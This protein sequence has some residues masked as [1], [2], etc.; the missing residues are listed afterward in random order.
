MA[1]HRRGMMAA[2][3]RRVSSARRDTA[4]GE[5]SS[6]NDMKSVQTDTNI[7][8]WCGVHKRSVYTQIYNTS[9]GYSAVQF[10]LTAVERG[11]EPKDTGAGQ[12]VQFVQSQERERERKLK[13]TSRLGS[14]ARPTAAGGGRKKGVEKKNNARVR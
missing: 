4:R 12:I 5:N 6:G 11:G 8:W 3:C 10:E 9:V 13:H 2:S 14:P 7:P 1:F